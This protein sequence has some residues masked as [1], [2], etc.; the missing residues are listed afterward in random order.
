MAGWSFTRALPRRFHYTGKKRRCQQKTWKSKSDAG[1][2]ALPLTRTRGGRAAGPRSAPSEQLEH[3]HLFRGVFRS[4][5]QIDVLAGIG[6][7]VVQLAAGDVQRVRAVHPHQFPSAVAH[8]R[9]EGE[10][11]PV[12][13][14]GI[15]ILA[16]NAVPVVI[17]SG[18]VR[19][20]RKEGPPLERDGDPDPGGF[21]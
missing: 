7:E 10:R 20:Q 17:R 8:H 16:V 5:V 18:F 15:V 11:V 13:D 21:A 2:S 19:E 1:D 14:V 3:P 12:V 4:A 9:E 6:F